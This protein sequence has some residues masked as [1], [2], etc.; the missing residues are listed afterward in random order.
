MFIMIG[1]VV[2]HDS[3]CLFCS[4]MITIVM[5]TKNLIMIIRH[6]EVM[7]KI[8]ETVESGGRELDVYLY[9]IIFLKF[10]QAVIPTIEY[11]Y[12]RNFTM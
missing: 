2:N 9:L 5:Q 3:C 4:I 6:A 8:I 1:V 12:T 11:D 10:V 7:K